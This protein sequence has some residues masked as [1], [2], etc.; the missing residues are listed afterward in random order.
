MRQSKTLPLLAGAAVAAMGTMPVMAAGAVMP[1]PMSAATARYY[2]SHPEQRAALLA[3]LASPAPA[4]SRFVTTTGGTWTNVTK[5][6]RTASL[7]SPVLLTDGTV[8]AQSANGPQWYKLTPDINGNYAT[9]TWTEVASLPVI[10]GT[11][12]A[13]LYHATAVLPDGRVIVM[14]GEYNGTGTGVWT[15]L[16]A[17]YD[18]VA[19][20]WTAVTA[21]SGSAWAQIGDAQSIVLPNGTF[22][23]ASCCAGPTANALLDPATLSWTAIG[24]PTAGAA[25]QDEQGYELLP[26]GNVLTID[27]WTNYPSGGA[28]NA[29]QYVPAT[30]TWISAG[31]TPESLPDPSACG[32]WEIGPA[33]MRGDGTLVAFGGNTGCV[34]GATTDPTV[35][36]TAKTGKWKAGPN[37]PATCGSRATS[38]CSVADAPAAVLPDGA[39]L[40]AASA[41]Y[42]DSPTHFF[43]YSATN[44]ISQVSDTLENATSSSCYFYNFLILPNG[45]VLE[46]DFSSTAEVY[47]PVGAAMTGWAPIVTKVPT[48]LTLGTAYTVEGKQLSGLSQGAYYGDDAQMATNYPLVRIVNTATGHV[49]YGKTTGFS[50]MSIKPKVEGS[51][52]FVLPTGIETGA[53]TLYVVANGIASKPVSV[54]VE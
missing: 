39:I 10:A 17:I 33:A 21:P 14:G 29:E 15:N 7:S 30:G 37:L 23:L 40:L 20:A 48:S 54:T 31:K 11:Q 18:P 2:A 44:T 52:K 24:G 13:P 45:Q 8:L 38:S 4:S 35:I 47:T 25:Y 19:N 49:F 43:E 12:Y 9:G 42:G 22:M 3:R 50:T 53:S 51:A 27:I 41:G 34:A 32:N 26:S 28:T 16:G 6:S 36:L 5:A 1:P 46:T